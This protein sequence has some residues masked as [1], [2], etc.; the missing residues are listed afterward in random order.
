MFC[1]LLCGRSRNAKFKNAYIS[2]HKYVKYYKYFLILTHCYWWSTIKTI[3]IICICRL[4]KIIRT[5]DCFISENGFN[6]A[7][8]SVN[9][10]ISFVHF[11]PFCFVMNH[12]QT[13]RIL[14]K[15][16]VPFVLSKE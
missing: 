7:D 1:C 10:L 12:S 8:I 6:T 16:A 2:F 14:N 15:T 3:C 11:K 5:N 13:R 9:S 4:S